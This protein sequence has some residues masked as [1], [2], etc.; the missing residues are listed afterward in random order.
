MTGSNF[1][2]SCTLED[3]KLLQK[4]TKNT[5]NTLKH[6]S[7]SPYLVIKLLLKNCYVC[8]MKMSNLQFR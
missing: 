8:D 3:A 5:I 1:V 2:F 6:W 7:G 4:H